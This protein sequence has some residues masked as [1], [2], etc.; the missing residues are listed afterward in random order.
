MIKTVLVHFIIDFR[1]NLLTFQSNIC[2]LRQKAKISMKELFYVLMFV[3]PLVASAQQPW[4]KY[5][6]LDY[7]WMNVGNTIFSAGEADFTSLAFSPSDSLPY[8]AYMDYGNGQKATVMKFNG[9]KWV[10]VGNAGFSAGWASYTSLAFSPSGEPYIA[11]EDW[12]NGYKATVMKFNGSNWVDVGNAGFS[13]GQTSDESFAFSPSGQP[14]VAYMDRAN[15]AKATVMKFHGNNWVYVGNAGFS[16]GEASG[17]SLA[18]NPADSMPYVAYQDIANSQKATVKKF[19]GTNWVNVGNAGFSA[20]AAYSPSLAFSTT[21]QPYV[22]YLDG[23]IDKA[24]V[25]KFDGTNWVNVGNAGFSAGAVEYQSLA[26]SPSDGQPYVA[27]C[28]AG[29][30]YKATVMTFNG[31]SWVNVGNAGFSDGE[32]FYTSLAFSPYGQP[33]VA[34]DISLNPSFYR[35]MVMI[36]DSV[37]VGIN[38]SQESR[39]LVYPNPAT[40]KITIELAEGQA[41]SQL[42]MMNLNG[43]EVLTRSLIKPKTQIDISNLPSGVYFVRLTN[44]NTVEVRMFV[45]E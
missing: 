7:I 21:G 6:P 23:N 24:T 31:S 35:A 41:P 32:A 29:N 33:Y 4:Y 3:F 45:K 39:L 17:E 1:K 2:M 11:Y 40:D 5:S 18:F 9:T 37:Y 36:Y 26:C 34:Y 15:S 10:N 12:G 20:G 19:D 28:D 22:A 42:S 16:A 8:V 14:S 13:A 25:M 38:E 43:E 44:N 27:Y 30:S